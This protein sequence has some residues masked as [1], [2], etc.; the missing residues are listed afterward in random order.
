M[1]WRGA[2]AVD[3]AIAQSM[4]SY[5]S[6]FGLVILQIT[7]FNL[8][9]LAVLGSVEAFI[10]RLT[11]KSAT[12]SGGKMLTMTR[13]E[14]RQFKVAERAQ[15][16]AARQAPAAR[17]KSPAP[18]SIYDLKLPIPGSPE[19][20]PVSR[21]AVT[22]LAT[23]EAAA[24]AKPPRQRQKPRPAKPLVINKPAEPPAIN[25]SDK[26]AEPPAINKSDKPA[27]PPV[28]N[29][30]DTPP[31]AQA[32]PP[33]IP[34]KAIAGEDA[35]FSRPF[36]KPDMDIEDDEQPAAPA[37]SANEPFARP[38]VMETRPP[39]SAAPTP[40][41]RPDRPTE[42]PPAAARPDQAKPYQSKTRPVPKPGKA[43]QPTTAQRPSAD[44]EELL[45]EPLEDGE[46][47]ADDDSFY[48]EDTD[49]DAAR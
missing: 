42:K 48:D 43:A 4:Q 8:G 49:E 2:A 11:G 6:S 21:Q 16:R 14:A 41:A 44:T 12:F 36:V 38:F 15:R 24:P 29:K 33:P 37:A 45:Y 5:L 3:A 18:K 25:K 22:V 31:K 35:P 9:A 26:P 40:S 19:R 28:I 27:E 17:T 47:Y 32:S 30:S 10:E 39:E 20:E 1:I 34:V 46:Y 13:E 7:L 23:A